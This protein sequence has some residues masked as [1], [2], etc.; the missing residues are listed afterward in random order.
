MPA[1]QDVATSPVRPEPTVLTT[2]SP[3]E[4]SVPTAPVPPTESPV[5]PDVPE[6]MAGTVL[7]PPEALLGAADLPFTPTSTN[8]YG[9]Y[10]KNR[11]MVTSLCGDGAEP[12]EELAVGGRQIF[13]IGTGD[14]SLATVVRVFEADGARQQLDF[15]RAS[16]GTCEYVTTYTPQ[17]AGGLPG[18]DALIG[19]APSAFVEGGTAVIGA[20]R[21]GSTTVGIQIDVEGDAAAATALAR[22]LLA[23][24]HELLVA[25]GLPAAHRG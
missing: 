20:V 5:N 11:T 12:G 16:L 21:D 1:P 19:T 8:D 10:V 6:G 7:V 2:P 23:R 14:D 3:V 18:D 24:G 13:H 9:P 4:P 15:L 25:S 22:G 17:D